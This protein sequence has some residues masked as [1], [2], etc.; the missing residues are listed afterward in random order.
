MREEWGSLMDDVNVE[1]A[2]KDGEEIIVLKI[3]NVIDERTSSHY[4]L[5]MSVETAW[6][7]IEKLNETFGE[8]W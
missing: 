8:M 5:P 7:L 4:R 1:V 3:G 6:K 2:R